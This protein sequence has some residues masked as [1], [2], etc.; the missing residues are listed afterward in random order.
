MPK[1]HELAHIMTLT[2]NGRLAWA[3]S[4]S[5]P[6]VNKDQFSISLRS[7]WS[8]QTGWTVPRNYEFAL[9]LVKFKAYS[10]LQAH[11]EGK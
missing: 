7:R 9:S 4:E 2:E 3:L 10:I 1:S 6:P 11:I 8:S 5:R